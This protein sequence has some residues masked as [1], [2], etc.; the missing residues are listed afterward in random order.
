[1]EDFIITVYCLIDEFLKKHA[2]EYI[3]VYYNRSVR[4]LARGKEILL[5]RVYLCYK[6][7]T[8]WIFLAHHGRDYS[9]RE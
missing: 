7:T 9:L 6:F 8:L 5:T 4:L 1:M 3:Q 2:L